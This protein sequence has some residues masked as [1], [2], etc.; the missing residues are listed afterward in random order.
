MVGVEAHAAVARELAVGH[1][2]ERHERARGRMLVGEPDQVDVGQRIAVDD[3]KGVGA[4]QRPRQAWAA[5]AAKHA[6]LL[7]GVA[8][9]RREVRAVPDNGG[10][11][12]RAVMEI[13]DEIV[14]ALRDEPADDA[15]NHRFT[16]DRNRRLGAN[17]GERAQA[18]TEAGSQDEGV[19][20]HSAM[21]LPPRMNRRRVKTYMV[22][23]SS[24]KAG[25]PK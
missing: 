4:E 9:A 6:R 17:V 25:K 19:A 18:G 15:A 1:E 8:Y 16:R 14:D 21:A 13:Q 5:C 3:Q 2:R 11:C 7:P 10:Q 22:K 12:L 20:N 24:A 23:H